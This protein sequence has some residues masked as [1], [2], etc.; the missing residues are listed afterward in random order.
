MFQFRLP[1]E[2]L[3]KLLH[4]DSE[5]NHR[6]IIENFASSLPVTNRTVTGGN[7]I[8]IRILLVKRVLSVYIVQR[9]FI[10]SLPI[11]KNFGPKKKQICYYRYNK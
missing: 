7:E 11:K 2:D 8:N 9:C 6:Q 4:V 1:K 5:E 3:E 10:S